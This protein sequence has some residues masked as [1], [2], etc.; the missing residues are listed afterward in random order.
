LRDYQR[1]RRKLDGRYENEDQKNAKSI[2]LANLCCKEIF[3][4]R[5]KDVDQYDFF[6]EH[7]RAVPVIGWEM[8]NVTGRN[9]PCIVL[10]DEFHFALHHQRHLFV[11]VAM[12][13]RHNERVKSETADH[14]LLTDNH[15]ALDAV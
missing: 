8:Q 6:V 3:P 1:P 9:D 10:N 2:H 15:L 7:R 11:R 13:G 5:G 12:R 4:D 14:Y